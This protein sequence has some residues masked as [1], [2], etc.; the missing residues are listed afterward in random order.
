[1]VLSVAKKLS[2]NVSTVVDAADIA[3]CILCQQQ[4]ERYAVAQ[5]YCTSRSEC[6][7]AFRFISLLVIQCVRDDAHPVE[8]EP[9]VSV[10]FSA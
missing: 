6:S 7:A 1:M 5:G 9:C 8:R 3:L 4:Y 10:D 2:V